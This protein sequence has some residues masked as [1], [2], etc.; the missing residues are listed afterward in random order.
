VIETKHIQKNGDHA[1]RSAILKIVI[2]VAGVILLVLGG[3]L[4]A[5]LNSHHAQIAA[6]QSQIRTLR[7]SLT[8]AH[9]QS[10]TAKA[11]MEAAQTQARTATATANANARA[12]YA[13]REAA[14]QKLQRKLARE[15]GIVQA[16]TISSDGV[17]VVGKDIPAGSYHT[18]GGGECYY[19]T[20]GSTDTSNIL[21]N[22]N[23][24]GPETVDVA[25]AYAFQISGGCT[26]T[27][28]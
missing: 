25:G 27:K 4:G 1:G 22:N 12:K 23:F 10:A 17:Y 7:Q 6:Q 26:W 14:V 28:A 16:S 15:Q 13:S 5:V 18:T 19:A 21:D 2:A 8:T 9:A 11:Q 3:V 20:L 24:N